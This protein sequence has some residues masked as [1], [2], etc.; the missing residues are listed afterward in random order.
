MKPEYKRVKGTGLSEYEKQ[1]ILKNIRKKSLNK[2]REE[3]GITFKSAREYLRSQNIKFSDFKTKGGRK[4]GWTFNDKQKKFIK[5]N[6]QKLSINKIAKII[7]SH[8][9]TVK[10]Y[11]NDQKIPY[12]LTRTRRNKEMI[13]AE[14]KDKVQP[15][16]IV[17]PPAI[18]TNPD[19][20]KMYL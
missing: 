18:Y 2:I 16:I 6:C 8:F 1:Y 11:L 20:S 15:N 5:D 19:Y 14:E 7:G 10:K 3:L 9:P 17:R 4:T 12:T 13:E